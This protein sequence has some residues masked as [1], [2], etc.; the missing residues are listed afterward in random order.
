MRAPNERGAALVAVLVLIL[1]LSG[2]AWTGLAQLRT[3]TDQVADA[4]ARAMATAAAREGR[5]TA[6]AMLARLKAQARQQP[7]LLDRPIQLAPAGAMVRIRFR[8][9][10]TCFN[11][12]SLAPGPNGDAPQ[13][14]P[15]QFARLLAAAGVPP[16]EADP[17][18]RA[19]AALLAAHRLLWAEPGEWLSVPGVTR[20]HWALVGRLLCTMPNREATALNANSLT[21][22]QAPLLVVI[23]LDPDE[24]RRAIARRPRGGW[25][26][27][28]DFWQ[29]A[30]P[31]GMPETAGAQVVGT[32]SRW[33]WLDLTAAVPGLAIRRLYLVDSLKS[34][35]R[36]AGA[37]WL[38]AGDAA[39]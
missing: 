30:S 14:K 34:P 28:T 36:I 15:E 4:R 11:L 10:S 12:N 1:M 32:S 20:K 39:A 23:G 29:I 5:E 31:S 24:A 21:A 9:A 3:A 37:I 25:T 17:L 26:S 18:A 8:D 2:L 6:L 27:T 38:P 13:T 19:S 16:L 33:F 7:G 22:D 35:A